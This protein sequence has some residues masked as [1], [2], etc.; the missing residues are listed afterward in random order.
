[1][2]VQTMQHCF[3]IDDTDFAKSNQVK[4]A[5]A[6]KHLHEKKNLSQKGEKFE[7]PPWSKW[8]QK[9]KEHVPFGKKKIDTASV[10]GIVNIIWLLAN[11]ASTSPRKLS[12]K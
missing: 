11:I 2:A 10:D 6:G 4:C 3:S 1:M 12:I 9:R 5:C 7:H 8:Y